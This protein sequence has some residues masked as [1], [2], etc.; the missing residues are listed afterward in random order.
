MSEWSHDY[1]TDLAE[2]EA[3]GVPAP[4]PIVH[5]CVKHDG[6]LTL[7]RHVRT[8][9]RKAALRKRHKEFIGEE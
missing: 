8:K 1:W 2:T 4:P 3:V 7:H 6:R 9:T 5:R